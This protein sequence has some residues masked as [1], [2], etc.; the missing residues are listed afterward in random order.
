MKGIE[1]GREGGREEEREREGER[2]KEST[3]GSLGPVF[4]AS[5]GPVFVAAVV[6]GLEK[7]TFGRRRSSRHR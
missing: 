2:E 7:S 5:L 3:F 4:V 1:K 6:H